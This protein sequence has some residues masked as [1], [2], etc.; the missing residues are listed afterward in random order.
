MVGALL[1]ILL[2]P[3]A[4][5]LEHSDQWTGGAHAA[6]LLQDAGFEVKPLPLDA[7]PSQLPDGLIV[8]GSFSCE[9]PGYPEYMGRYKDDLL[10][11]IARGN[12][13]LQLTQADQFESSPPFLP[14][15]LYARRTDPDFSASHVI[16]GGHPL[17]AGLP[18]MQFSFHSQ[19]TV[20]EGFADQKGF[21]VVMA[22]HPDNVGP[23]LLE[24]AHGSG[25]VVLTSMP[26][27]K[28]IAPPEGRTPAAD[29]EFE[30]FRTAFFKNL[31]AYVQDVR[32]GRAAA[33]S[34]TPSQ[35]DVA[36][37]DPGSWSLIVLPD[38][39]VYAESFPGLFMAQTG[40][41]V[42]NKDRLDVKYVLQLGDITNRNTP[43]Q[44]RVAREAMSL[45]DGVV[46]YAIAPGNHDFGPGGNA[47]TRHTYFNDYFPFA[48]Q[49]AMPTFGG[50]MHDGELENTFHLF[51]AGG[52]DW[53]VLSLEWGP[54][55]EVVAWANTV[56][57]AHRDRTGILITHAYVY[58]DSTRYDW[59]THGSKQSWNPYA[60][61]T[62]GGVNDGEDLWQ[63]LVRRHN[64]A[65]TINGHVLGDGTGYVA[66][67]NDLGFTTH[68]ILANYQFRTLGGEAYLRVFEFLQDGKTV[69]IK[70]YSPLYGRHI[71]KDD[72][73]FTLTL[74]QPR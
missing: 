50:A 67:K 16:A 32:A 28:T 41:I 2:A 63:K 19:R 51:E 11:F 13:A 17:L 46:P 21:R 60:Y 54:R 27:D 68:Q 26:L 49:A 33:V 20:W 10:A 71:L 62:E 6:R 8:F 45:L 29:A 1:P 73:T 22:S 9:M 55:D 30:R 56:M 64:F 47:K 23:S 18:D 57:A 7:S 59:K 48:Q 72:H 34:P 43:E 15:A 14:D 58:N 12:V 5:V 24:G 69:K 53:I 37:F 52:R 44:W 39:Q 38:T 35:A 70:A 42:A 4:Y 36:H 31:L 3:T 74:D 40:W 66:S 61:D 25:R 65:F